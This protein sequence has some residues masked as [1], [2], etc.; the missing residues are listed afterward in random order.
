MGKKKYLIQII[1]F[2]L[3]MI[4]MSGEEDNTGSNHRATSAER[5]LSKKEEINQVINS[6]YFVI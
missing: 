2:L 6:G 4:Q 1:F 3:W 5:T